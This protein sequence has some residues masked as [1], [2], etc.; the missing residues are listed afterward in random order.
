METSPKRN[1]NSRVSSPQR[2]VS[3]AEAAYLETRT[4]DVLAEDRRV[5]EQERRQITRALPSAG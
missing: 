3:W 5:E 2:R 1:S 4:T